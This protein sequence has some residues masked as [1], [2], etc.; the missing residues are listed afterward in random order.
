MIL[1]PQLKDIFEAMF[2]IK[3]K[4]V[5]HKSYIQEPGNQ[6]SLYKYFRA[7]VII[8]NHRTPSTVVLP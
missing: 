2:S 6:M 5:R 4:W 3:K 1:A 7:S 8:A